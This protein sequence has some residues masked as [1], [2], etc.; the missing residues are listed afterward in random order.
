MHKL[1]VHNVQMTKEFFYVWGDSDSEVLDL[2]LLEAL[3]RGRYGESEDLDIA[4]ALTELIHEQLELRAT[5]ANQTLLDDD[6]KL[7]ILAHRATL[8][9]LGIEF[10]LPFR[11]FSGFYRQWTKLGLVGSGSWAS[12]RGYLAE[13]FEPLETKLAE[14]DEKRYLNPIASPPGN[15][16]TGWNEVDKALHQMRRRFETARTAAEYKEVGLHAVSVIE[17]LS[18]AAFDESQLP[19]GEPLPPVGNTMDRIDVYIRF[20]LSGRD[21]EILRG[22]IRKSNEWANKV[23]HRSTP[24]RLDAGIAA[25]AVTLLAST[26]RR[27]HDTTNG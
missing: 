23:K 15:A 16:G 2:E 1:E 4:L 10:N 3:R 17:A 11:D 20:N 12:R 14:L 21:N 22:L 9:R 19:P 5:F 18:A 26:L 7:C 8:R 6:L 25:D 27:L 13:L 24:G